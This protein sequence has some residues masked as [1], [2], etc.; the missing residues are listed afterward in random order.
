MKLSFLQ[1]KFSPST[2][3]DPDLNFQITEQIVKD[4]STLYLGRGNHYDYDTCHHGMSP[5]A[6]IPLSADA[7]R[8]REAEETALA[9]ASQTTTT[10]HKKKRKYIPKLILEFNPLRLFL[11]CLNH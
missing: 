8:E 11:K 10:D 1:N 5:F 4:F 6:I 2:T 7:H 3:K 9:L